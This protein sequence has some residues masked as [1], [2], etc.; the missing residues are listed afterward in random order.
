[1]TSQEIISKYPL[2]FRDCKL[3]VSQ[4]CMA[5]GI[6]TGDGWLQLIDQLSQEL[7]STAKQVVWYAQI[8]EKFGTLRVYLNYAASVSNE[9]MQEVDAILDKY[10]ELSSRVCEQCGKPGKL[11]RKGWWTTACVDHRTLTKREKK[12]RRALQRRRSLL[13]LQH[14]KATEI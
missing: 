1:V 2:L 14:E 9:K 13:N 3:P 7:E 6:D 8:K 12:I 4:S 10:Q 11:V 5:F